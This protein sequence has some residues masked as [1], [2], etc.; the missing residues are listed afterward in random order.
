MVAMAMRRKALLLGLVLVIAAGIGLYATFQSRYL[1]EES[2]R[3]HV[4]SLQQTVQGLDALDRA[5][6]NAIAIAVDSA[7]FQSFGS[8]LAGGKVTLTHPALPGEILTVTI[9]R[10]AFSPGPGQIRSDMSLNVTSDKRSFSV[11]L[12]VQAGLYF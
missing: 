9:E 10:I 5:G 4:V 1:L 3:A 12:N 8:A 7:F 6:P 2:E 11:G